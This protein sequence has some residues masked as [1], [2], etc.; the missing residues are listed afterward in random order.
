MPYQKYPV[1]STIDWLSE[2]WLIPYWGL[3]WI[4]INVAFMILPTY[5]ARVPG[6]TGLVHNSS[7]VWE[8]RRCLIRR[9]Y[10]SRRRRCLIRHFYWSRRHRCLIRHFYWSRR[11]RCLIRHF[12]SS[13]RRRSLVT[14]PLAGRSDV[15][16]NNI[17]HRWQ[18]HGSMVAMTNDSM[19]YN[20][21]IC[22]CF[23]FF[24]WCK[25]LP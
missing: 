13:P 9:F 23:F 22:F 5:C 20:A 14:F 10:W 24:L 19:L 16:E 7:Q 17:W 3:Q 2:L 15:D 6:A 18:W 25:V 4:I 8:E 12:Y 1:Y 11:H 21:M